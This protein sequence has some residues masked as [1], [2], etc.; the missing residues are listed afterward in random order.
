MNRQSLF[1]IIAVCTLGIALLAG[2]P[3]A[4]DERGTVGG[5]ATVA[6]PILVYHR[7]GQTAADA[8]TTPTAVFE[9]QLQYLR[10]HGYTVVP[11]RQVVDHLLH[12]GAP[13]PPRAVVITADDGHRSVY[14]IL[15]PLARRHHLPVTLFIY[16]SAISNATYALTWEQ[17][18]EM[19]ASGLFDIQSHTYWHPD[20]R[21]ERRRLA[22]AAYEQLVV[23]Q[24]VKARRKLVEELGG[25]VD[26]LAWPFGIHDPWLMQKAREA[27]YVAAFTIEPRPATARDDPMAF[28]RYL[29]TDTTRV[30]GLA[31]LLARGEQRR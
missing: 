12:G 10:N 13:P 26:L 8:M 28:P 15:F 16:P 14:T 3:A 5:S 30:R 7:F 18:R 11:L 25:E 29:L 17:L 24:L 6:V 31:N 9:E 1:T 23:T 20:F 19:R 2:T 22:A 21:Q 27:G 4:S